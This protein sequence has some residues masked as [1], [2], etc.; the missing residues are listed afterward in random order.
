MQQLDFM[1]AIEQLASIGVG[2]D[3]GLTD[4]EV[5]AVQRHF[6]LAFPADLRAFLQTAMPVSLLPIG[7]YIRSY[8]FPDW[9]HGDEEEIKEKLNWPFEGM[10]FDIEHNVFWMEEW[11]PRPA[12]IAE[13]CAIARTKL[14][15]APTLIPIYSHR[16]MPDSPQTAGNPIY[17]VYQTDIIYYG[18]D[19]LDY[20]ANEFG[21][22]VERPKPLKPRRVDFW[23]T[24]PDMWES[25]WD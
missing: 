13:A 8:E 16:Y 25:V 24:L 11:G 18:S 12:S 2:F 5:E 4:V 21:I 19:L 7:G 15:E 23:A 6:G 17:S 1:A 10:C 22:A 20:F 14:N 3:S 9:R